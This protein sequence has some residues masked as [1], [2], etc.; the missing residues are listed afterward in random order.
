MDVAK[1]TLGTGNRK[2]VLTNLTGEQA[3]LKIHLHNALKNI[4]PFLGGT[5]NYV[6]EFEHITPKVPLTMDEF[7]S[8]GR[9]GRQSENNQ[10]IKAPFGVGKTQVAQTGGLADVVKEME[11]LLKNQPKFEPCGMSDSHTFID[12]NG[13]THVF[14]DTYKNIENIIKPDKNL[15]PAKTGGLSQVTKEMSE[16]EKIA[17]ELLD[18]DE[19]QIDPE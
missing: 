9:A 19:I 10:I 6:K 7:Q 16:K 11:K 3:A 2:R 14:N 5:S 13:K 17:R 8:I 18:K 1:L 4:P 15:P 12:R